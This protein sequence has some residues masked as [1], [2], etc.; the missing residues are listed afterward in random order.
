MSNNNSFT[1]P[2]DGKKFGSK[3]ALYAH[4]E[5]AYP[6]MVTDDMPASR[7]YFNLKYKKTVGKCVMS[8]K[9]TKWNNV[10][11]RYERF[12]GEVEK[13]AYREQFKERMM[14][15]YGRTHLTDDPEHQKLMLSNRSIAAQYKWHDGAVTKVTGTYEEHFL[16]FIES[17]Y[18]FRAEM[19][20]EPPT[21]YYKEG[22]KVRFYLPDFFIPSLNLIVEIKGSNPHYQQRDAEIETLKR[23]ATVAEGFKYL[24]L[25]DKFYTP[26]NVF[27][28][29]EVLEKA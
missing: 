6:Q 23:D 24:Q 25:Q 22:D 17:V 16:H 27:F 11:E 26:F 10:T 3:P 13:L 7:L 15:K 28:K 20:A 9:P 19:L 2:L 4:I 29:Q 18:H 8:G 12:A 5:E 1:F 21:I 14:S